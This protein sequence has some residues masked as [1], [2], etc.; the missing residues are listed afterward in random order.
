VDEVDAVQARAVE[1]GLEI[2]YDLR[3]EKWG[4][5]RFD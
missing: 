2:A 5:R 3:D 1:R 4:V